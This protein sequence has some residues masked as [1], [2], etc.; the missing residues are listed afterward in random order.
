[1]VKQTMIKRTVSVLMI[2]LFIL[3]SFISCTKTM[4]KGA[5]ESTVVSE[6]TT[7]TSEETET[8]K[9]YEVP[10]TLND[11]FDNPD[12]YELTFYDD[13]DGTQLDMSKW[14]YCPDWE[15]G[16]VGGRWD[17]SMISLDGNGNLVVTSSFLQ[18]SDG[19]ITP[20]SGAIRTNGKF[21]Q[22]MGYFEIRCKLQSAHGFWFAFWLMCDGE[23]DTTDGIRNGAEMDI[24]EAF[25]VD[26]GKVNHALHWDG[27]DSELK[28]ILRPMRH[29]ECYDGEFH[30]FSLLWNEN[31][32]IFY[33]DGE[34]S[35][36]V[37]ENVSN[38]P[39]VCEVPT[40]LKITS[41]FGTWTS[42]YYI[43]ELP[44]SVL[45]DYVKVYQRK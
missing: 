20:I 11:F 26:Y 15:R 39:G 21:E 40:Y 1:M 23:K 42:Y 35:T 31:G 6:S 7:E 9:E 10:L 36:T 30:T 33:V 25:D 17:R 19:S 41:E 37:R 27:Y 8:E 34:I 2:I 4:E 43:D 45:V 22:C 29:K 12:Q 28:S 13:F 32:Y 14:N 16:N 24:V 38:F 3:L 18:N 5:D 44:D